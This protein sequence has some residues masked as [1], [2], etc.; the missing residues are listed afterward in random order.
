MKKIIIA[1]PPTKSIIDAISLA[2]I[3]GRMKPIVTEDI[4]LKKLRES[5]QVCLN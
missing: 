3:T 2:V 5:V 1:I 4:N